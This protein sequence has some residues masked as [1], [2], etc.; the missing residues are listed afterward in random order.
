MSRAIHHLRG[1]RGNARREYHAG[2]EREF[3][4][5]V[6]SDVKLLE[7]DDFLGGV[8]RRS[9]EI[10]KVSDAELSALDSMLERNG[11]A[12]VLRSIRELCDGR[13]EAGAMA[14]SFEGEEGS[15][16]WK[17]HADALESLLATIRGLT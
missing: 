9:D 1:V 5:L 7:S 13:G 8:F 14:D 3:D 16:E 6:A 17:G 15:D 4:A 12:R 10:Q 11:L 2:V